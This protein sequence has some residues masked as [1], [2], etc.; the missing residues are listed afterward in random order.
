M[1]VSGKYFFRIIKCIVPL[2]YIRDLHFLAFSATVGNMKAKI[3]REIQRVFNKYLSFS[4]DQTLVVDEVV[5]VTRPTEESFGDYTSNIALTSSKEL[6][7]SPR[8]I[9]EVVKMN[10]LYLRSGRLKLPAWGT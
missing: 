9:A 10:S 1:G 3:A 7:K 8:E 5:H 6:A 4:D 2:F